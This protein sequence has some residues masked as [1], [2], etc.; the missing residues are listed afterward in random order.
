MNQEIEWLKQ[1]RPNVR[2]VMRRLMYQLRKGKGCKR[3]E[4]VKVLDEPKS[5]NER[6]WNP[7][8]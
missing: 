3:I 7:Q 8:R 1:E 4:K 5:I 2:I 6:S